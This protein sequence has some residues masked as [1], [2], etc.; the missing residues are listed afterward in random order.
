M[1]NEAL[2]LRKLTTDEPLPYAL[3]LLADETR[4]AIDRYI[5]DCEVWVAHGLNG[6]VGVIAVRKDVDTAEVMNIAVAGSHRNRGIGSQLLQFICAMFRDHG[7]RMI[8]VGCADAG[9][10]QQRFYERHGFHFKEV[11]PDFYLQNYP[12]PI[13]ENGRQLKDMWMYEREL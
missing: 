8:F 11:R 13:F 10:D 7:L 3:L 9:V 5:F 6:S 4:Q 2:E 1:K 12:E